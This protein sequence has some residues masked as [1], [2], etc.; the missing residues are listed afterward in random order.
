MQKNLRLIV[1]IKW[2][3][4]EEWKSKQSNNKKQS[5]TQ[6]KNKNK[7]M[8]DRAH[9]FNNFKYKTQIL[10]MVSD[11]IIKVDLIFKIERI[12]LNL[13]KLLK[14]TLRDFNFIVN[15][16]TKGSP[17][18]LGTIL[19]IT[20]HFSVTFMNTSHSI[21]LMFSLSKINHLIQFSP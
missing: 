20:L 17:L 12:T 11:I 21:K 9:K 6:F 19:S 5:S 15:I 4:R 1:S 18:G 14:N 8:I 3:L 13:S 2:R 16:I 7:L 10:S